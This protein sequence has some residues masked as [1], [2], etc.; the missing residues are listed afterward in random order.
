[1]KMKKKFTVSI[2]AIALFAD[3]AFAGIEKSKHD[4]SYDRKEEIC[5][6]CH[7]PQRVYTGPAD[8]TLWNKAIPS[9]VYSVYGAPITGIPVDTVPFTLSKACFSCHDGLQA[10]DIKFDKVEEKGVYPLPSGTTLIGQDMM[11]RTHAYHPVSLI[12]TEGKANL[13]P[14]GE[15]LSGWQGANT[16]ADLLRNGKVECVSCHDPHAGDKP[17]FLRRHNIKSSL[18]YGCHSK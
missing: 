5:I 10:P 1:M 14:T 15:M 7:T 6:W 17:A 9:V 18:C 12:Y 4:L 13:K 11:D 16:V 8:V 2:L 3:A